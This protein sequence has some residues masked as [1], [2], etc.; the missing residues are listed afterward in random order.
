MT[1]MTHGGGQLYKSKPG[2]YYVS[3]TAGVM[4]ST[5]SGATWTPVG[6]VPPSTSVFGD[7]TRLYSHSA[8]LLGSQPFSSSLES[9]GVTWAPLNADALSDGPFEMAFDAKQGIVYSANWGNGLLALKV[10]PAP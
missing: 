10:P 8:Y 2:P 7:G 6:S 3:S 1:A 5:D 4:R 9:D